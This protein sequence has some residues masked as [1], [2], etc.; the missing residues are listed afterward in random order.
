MR[1]RTSLIFNAMLLLFLVATTFMG[2]AQPGATTR[3]AIP[4]DPI[5]T[6]FKVFETYSVVA[7][8]EGAHRNIQSHEFRLSLLHDPRFPEV[9]NDIVVECGNS[10]YQDIMD[11]FTSGKDVAYDELR[12]V[13]QKTTQTHGVCNAPIYEEFFRAVRELNATLPESRQI[14]VLLG[15][16]PVDRERQ[17]DE[18]YY[19]LAGQRNT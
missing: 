2:Q 5:D 11:R 1:K 8:G 17:S 3:A 4:L 15:D 12:Q 19:R 6:I 9:V 16:P 18:E 7:L 10:L 13:W 14:R